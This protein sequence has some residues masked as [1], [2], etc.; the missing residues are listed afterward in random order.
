MPR[1]ESS[2]VRLEGA[3]RNLRRQITKDQTATVPLGSFGKKGQEAPIGLPNKTVGFPRL[4]INCALCHTATYRVS[5]SSEPA[6]VVGAASN[7]FDLQ[8]YL[9]FL[10][11]CAEDPRFT[12]EIVLRE[13]KKNYGLSWID[14]PSGQKLWGALQ[15]D[16]IRRDPGALPAL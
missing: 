16:Q 3:S 6:I 5:A 8:A 2:V 14:S 4:G 10:T 12:P 1:G 11:A 15:R 7:T 13:I 9:S